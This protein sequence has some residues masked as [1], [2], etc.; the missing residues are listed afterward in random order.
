MLIGLGEAVITAL[1]LAAVARARPELMDERP[2][3]ASRFQMTTVV[4]GLVLALGLALF[5]APYACS[6]P[7]GL[8]Y[9][10]ARLG[11]GE[12][13]A[14]LAAP[15]KQYK[16]PWVGSMAW[17]TALAGVIGTMVA[18]AVAIILSLVLAPRRAPD[19]AVTS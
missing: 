1:V 12:S 13:P 14:V 3:S 6:W 5:V 10:A 16:L 4:M 18:F 15:M 2:T 11:M 19:P 9:V 7:D 8:E 17:A